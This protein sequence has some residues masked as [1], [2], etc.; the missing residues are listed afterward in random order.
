MKRIN[1]MTSKLFKSGDVREDGKLFY[2]Y[3]KRM[4][5]KGEHFIEI[6]LTPHAFNRNRLKRVKN[7]QVKERYEVNIKNALIVKEL[8][9]ELH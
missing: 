2:G 7:D 4:P 6:W 5:K 8:Q 1:P 9:D 3:T